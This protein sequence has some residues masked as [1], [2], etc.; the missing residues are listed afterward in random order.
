MPESLLDDALLRRTKELIVRKFGIEVP[1]GRDH[2]LEKAIFAMAEEA[3]L[4]PDLA[5]EQ[6]QIRPISD[7]ALRTLIEGLTINETH[8]FRNEPQFRVLRSQILP[9]LIKERASAKKLRIWSAACSS[10]EE[11]YSV[12]MSLR[13]LIPD[14]D[15]WNLYILGTDIDRSILDK[16]GRATYGE[17]SF[18]QVPEEFDGFFEQN[19]GT[20]T[21]VPEARNMVQFYQQNLVDVNSWIGDK[22]RFGKMDVIFCR[23]VLIYF[24]EE[25]T[26]RI[27]DALYE[28][29]NP[30]GWLIVGHADPSQDRFQKFATHTFPQTIIYQ[31]PNDGIEPGLVAAISP[32]AQPKVILADI[33]ELAKRDPNQAIERLLAVAGEPD[34][35]SQRTIMLARLLA[36]RRRLPEAHDQAVKAVQLASLSPEAYYVQGTI[37]REMGRAD[38]ALDVFRRAV[39]LDKNFVLAKVQ[40]A[41]CLSDLGQHDRARR[42]L[43]YAA[44]MI[45]GQPAAGVVYGDPEI[46]IGRLRE[47]IGSRLRLLS[48]ND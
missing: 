22:I 36:S 11:P 1:T 33:Q 21:V 9:D 16:A 8:F 3:Q 40:L 5:V 27:I 17:W 6:I 45:E 23:N 10:G 4:P 41:E 29:L 20:R 48:S 42:E 2:E 28:C 31:R 38:Q 46:T 43:Q 30:G 37:L 24:D 47:M 32:K 26:Q 13:T 25:T 44:E 14:V 12:A 18:R 19:G 15:D 34:P 7:P 35:A 39:F